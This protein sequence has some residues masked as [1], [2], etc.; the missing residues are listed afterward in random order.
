MKRTTAL[1]STLIAISTLAMGP[2]P[3]EETSVQVRPGD[4][5][6]TA[7][8]NGCTVGFLLDEL[9]EEGFDTGT[10]WFLT[11][12]HCFV[13]GGK[14]TWEIGGGPDVQVGNE[15]VGEVVYAHK[16][17]PAATD[18]ALVRLTV[19][20]DAIDPSVCYWGGPVATADAP[21]ADGDTVLI[22]GKGGL[23][24]PRELTATADQEAWVQYRGDHGGG[25]SGGP[26]MDADGR[27]L[28]IHATGG[29]KTSDLSTGAA[30]RITEMVALLED[31]FAT[32]FVLMTADRSDTDWPVDAVTVAC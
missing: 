20:E 28:G 17:W 12:G 25:D 7:E 29:I 16:D 32:D 31:E 26:I 1:L 30:S 3:A 4:F 8:G 14:S 22:T 18:V 24:E 2:R 21:P 9:D 13:N 5:L 6:V 19:G 27:A 11:A 23:V 10:N 15:S